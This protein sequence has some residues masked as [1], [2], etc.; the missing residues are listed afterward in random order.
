MLDIKTNVGSAQAIWAWLDLNASDHGAS[1]IGH[2]RKI[3]RPV[4]MRKDAKHT[5]TAV[6]QSKAAATFLPEESNSILKRSLSKLRIKDGLSPDRRKAEIQSRRQPLAS[7]SKIP[8]ATAPT[9]NAHIITARSDKAA[10]VLHNVANSDT[11]CADKS[12][13]KNGSP[14]ENHPDRSA[15]H[16]YGF[17][18][19][20]QLS[21]IAKT[22]S[23]EV[24]TKAM[25]LGIFKV[26]EADLKERYQFLNEIGSGEWG[27]VWAVEALRPLAH[28]PSS[29]YRSLQ[30]DKLTGSGTYTIDNTS[31]FRPLAVKLCKRETKYSSAARTQRLWNEFKVLRTLMDQLPRAERVNADSPNCRVRNDR[32]GWHPN[33]VNFYEFLLTPNLAML[34][35]PKFDEPMKVCLGETL[36]LN[37]FQQLLSA[38]H[39]L[40]QHGVCHNDIKVDNLGVTYD[41]SGLGRDV[42][43]LFDFG[44]AHRYDPPKKGAFMSQEV[45]GTPEY[46]SPERC[47]AMLHDERKSDMWALG[48]TF[49]EMRTGRTPFEHHD[50]KFDSSEKFEVYYERAE[51]GTWLGDWEMSTEMED[52]IRKM[53]R[54]DP[55]ERLDAAEALAHPLVD[56]RNGK[57]RDS[58]DDFLQISYEEV[59][60]FDAVPDTRRNAGLSQMLREIDDSD[61][62][63]Q[64]L[65]EQSNQTVIEHHTGASERE[66]LLASPGIS[67]AAVALRSSRIPASP[68][69]SQVGMDSRLTDLMCVSPPWRGPRPPRQGTPIPSVERDRVLAEKLVKQMDNE[70]DDSDYSVSNDSPVAITRA[71]RASVARTAL[72]VQPTKQSPF[73]LRL[74]ERPRQIQS[75]RPLTEQMTSTPVS[76]PAI[77][78]QKP[79]AP[80][81]PPTSL[82]L[83]NHEKFIPMASRTDFCSRGNVVA[84]LAKK[85]DASNFLAR[86]PA[87][88]TAM[89]TAGGLGLTIRGHPVHNAGHSHRRSKSY[90]LVSSTQQDIA[91]QSARRSTGSMVPSPEDALPRCARRL[92][93]TAEPSPVLSSIEADSATD[94]GSARSDTKDAG[95]HHPQA[96]IKSA[97][98][99]TPNLHAVLSGDSLQQTTLPT[100]SGPSSISIPSTPSAGEE[101]IFRK[102]KKMASLAGL[103]SKMIDETK[104]TILTPERSNLK[105]PMRT[106][107]GSVGTESTEAV[108]I[109]PGLLETPD[110]VG[111]R[112]KKAEED[113]GDV[114]LVSAAFSLDLSGNDRR[115]CSN[116]PTSQVGL[117]Q[118]SV[119][120][121]LQ[122]P[123]DRTPSITPSAAQVETMY[124]SFLLSQNVCKSGNGFLSPPHTPSVADDTAASSTKSKH[125]SLA[126]LFSPS[127]TTPLQSLLKNA[128]VSPRKTA[129]GDAS[130]VDHQ[131]SIGK[132]G[133][134]SRLFRKHA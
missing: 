5:E 53:L 111:G 112:R 20:H 9:P 94:I 12:R 31:N 107:R 83:V 101:V 15:D 70:G 90:T 67:R 124:S 114:S 98:S 27:S 88:V 18:G 45:W 81:L 123:S 60:A 125:R 106:R 72:L 47:R 56:P 129:G 95:M 91:H 131:R 86:P 34:V 122:S 23:E 77:I 85:F 87:H 62:M 61:A 80:V 32:T 102:L 17:S 24:K 84:S 16:H 50:E 48:I 52:L 28:L 74:G 133:K 19:T 36:C 8:Q 30:V 43:T 76:A 108:D 35:M 104:S 2:A 89:T 58:F 73:R 75:S 132:S 49:F 6:S 127:G 55:Q 128:R 78:E 113:E 26:S 37:F 120:P 41:T 57:Q 96:C 51:R 4:S 13:H 29:A 44:F 93:A 14:A 11:M 110:T 130:R 69:L 71:S 42:V 116:V 105:T 118:V 66:L 64:D 99:R 100:R 39:W 22:R 33:V 115:E 3:V 79:I 38:L 65:V 59:R 126:T 103:L 117:D 92:F 7:A 25:Q 109:S 46:L 119:Q 10:F 54:H 82:P 40:H 1:E 63:I 68:S 121:R 97:T 21:P 134:L